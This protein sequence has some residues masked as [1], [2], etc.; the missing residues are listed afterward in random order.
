MGSPAGL[1]LKKFQWSQGPMTYFF[2]ESE[3]ILGGACVFLKKYV[4]FFK[5]K[6]FWGLFLSFS[7]RM[8]KIWIPVC[9]YLTMCKNLEDCWCLFLKIGKE[10][11]DLLALCFW[12]N[13][14]DRAIL[15][16]K[17]F[18]ESQDV[19]RLFL[20]MCMN[21]RGPLCFFLRM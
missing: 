11:W 16:L 8:W 7:L 14:G 18:K 21:F 5:V 9:L 6:K 12:K 19:F 2:K 17:E 10:F 3:R 1:V 20:I 4:W 13:L 15:Y